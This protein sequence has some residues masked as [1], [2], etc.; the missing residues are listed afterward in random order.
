MARMT[1]PQYLLKQAQEHP[2]DFSRHAGRGP[3]SHVAGRDDTGVGKACFLGD[4]RAAF[5]D[6]DF[7]VVDG[8]LEGRG[9]ADDAGADDRYP[10][11]FPVLIGSSAA[12]ARNAMFNTV[13]SRIALCQIM[14]PAGSS[15]AA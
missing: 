15:P 6:R 10:H 11:E 4:G 3:W 13:S 12:S 1:L 2:R 14:R 5:E 8:Q 7:V 9:D